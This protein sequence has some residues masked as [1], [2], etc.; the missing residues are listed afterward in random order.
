MSCGTVS[1]SNKKGI[2]EFVYHRNYVWQWLAAMH[3]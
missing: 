1:L 3:F 2:F